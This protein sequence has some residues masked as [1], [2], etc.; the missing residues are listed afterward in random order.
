MAYP[1]IH[2]FGHDKEQI[3]TNANDECLAK[4]NGGMTMLM[5]GMVFH[6]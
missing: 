4:L 6:R 2:G 3:K 5:M 1:A